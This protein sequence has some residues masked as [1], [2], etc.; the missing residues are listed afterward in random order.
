MIWNK[1]T[2]Q[3]FQFQKLIYVY[4]LSNEQMTYVGLNIICIDLWNILGEILLVNIFKVFKDEIL[5]YLSITIFFD[6][7][8]ISYITLDIKLEFV[9]LVV[10]IKDQ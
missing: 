9:D 8:K 4:I 2:E 3:F 10:L 5:L 1:I 7:L 6:Q